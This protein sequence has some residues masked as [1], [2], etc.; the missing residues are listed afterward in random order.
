LL[1]RKLGGVQQHEA[2]D[3]VSFQWYIQL[4]AVGLSEVSGTTIGVP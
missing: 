2:P 3:A 4:F 1:M